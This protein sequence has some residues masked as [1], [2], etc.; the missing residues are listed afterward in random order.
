MSPPR[1]LGRGGGE[2]GP[3]GPQDWGLRLKEEE[4]SLPTGWWERCVEA[5]WSCGSRQSPPLAPCALISPEVP[6]ALPAARLTS[7]LHF[8]RLEVL[9]QLL[10]VCSSNQHP[11][12]PP[13]GHF[14][15]GVPQPGTP[16]YLHMG[17]PLSVP[18]SSQATSWERPSS[19]APLRLQAVPLPGVPLDLCP[20]PVCVA[21]PAGFFLVRVLGG[22]W[23]PGERGLGS[24]GLTSRARAVPNSVGTQPIPAGWRN[25]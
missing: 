12:L 24:L 25:E 19:P 16:K 21:L 15:L 6:Q 2:P 18:I 8:L 3:H 1:A 10:A 13:S 23:A 11:A 5:L 20:S 17:L 4:V 14:A 7:A 22:T 9:F